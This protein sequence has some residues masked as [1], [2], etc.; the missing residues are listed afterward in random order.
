MCAHITWQTKGKK[1]VG[2]CVFLTPYE[3]IVEEGFVNK[4]W[5]PIENGLLAPLC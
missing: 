2:V 4:K 5:D 3:Q 1:K